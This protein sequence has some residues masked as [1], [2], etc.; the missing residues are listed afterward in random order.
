VFGW[1]SKTKDEITE[2]IFKEKIENNTQYMAAKST[3][4][5]V[6]DTAEFNNSDYCNHA[7]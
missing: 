4:F 6:L 5:K 1:I 3:V 2:I 7:K